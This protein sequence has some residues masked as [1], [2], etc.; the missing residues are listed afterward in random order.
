M[1][2]D[3]HVNFGY[4]TVI[5]GSGVISS[6][7]GTSLIINATGDLPDPASGGAYNVTV[8]PSATQPTASSA[9]IMRVTA[10]SGT[11]LT[12][13]RA[14]EGT[15][16]LGSILAGYQVAATA[17]K[18]LFTDIETAIPSGGGG[19][20]SGVVSGCSVTHSAA[21]ACASGTNTALNFDT[22]DWDT[23]GYHDT[24]TNNTRLTLPFTGKFLITGWIPWAPQN[25]TSRRNL[26]V[27]KN[28]SVMEMRNE[29]MAASSGAGE[30]N[31]TIAVM[32]NGVAGD[33]YELIAWQN[34]GSSLSSSHTSATDLR[35]RFQIFMLASAFSGGLIA[36][37]QYAPASLASYSLSTS[38]MTALDTTNL[39]V[40]PFTVPGSGNILV[41][42]KAYCVVGTAT[43]NPVGF[44]LLNHTGG[45][46]V[47][48][49]VNAWLNATSSAQGQPNASAFF[50]V[51]GLTPGASLQ[52]DFAACVGAASGTIFAQGYTG[53]VSNS[54]SG[55][56]VIAV[57]AA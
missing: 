34:S 9:E 52:L 3:Q 1:A 7:S 10:K 33:Y 57:W 53:L 5:A 49:T 43:N 32:V 56:I 23:D 20:G 54:K 46:Q 14:Q 22:E 31:N 40:G 27:L 44:G 13:T 15:T 37:K 24:V 4:S 36:V 28:G 17:T 25:T 18:K 48:Q 21:Q 8:W 45:A 29:T 30:P 47:G 12:V 51:T 6:T 16:A 19:G 41:E 39:T 2:F 50:Y 55:P 35:V 42:V 38:A 26:E 11:T